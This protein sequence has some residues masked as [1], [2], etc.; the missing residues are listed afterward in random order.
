MKII[1]KEEIILIGCFGNHN[2]GAVWGK[3][4]EMTRAHEIK[5]GVTDEE[6][7]SAAHEVRFY[8]E[9]GEHIFAGVEVTQKDSGGAW[10]Y[11]VLPE[12]LYAVFDIDHK[13]DQGPQYAAI[14]E[15][16]AANA[17]TYKRVMWDA[18]GKTGL[19]EFVIC[20]YDHRLTG[21]FKNSRVMEMWIPVSTF[22]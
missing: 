4:E 13:I 12:A 11:L 15:W 22:N 5:H 14:N 17:D 1:E 7:N 16:L 21:K 9:S 10:E 19:S 2:A 18:D 3:W 20:R 8:P 6:N